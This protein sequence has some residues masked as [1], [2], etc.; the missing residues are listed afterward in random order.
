MWN[1]LDRKAK[2][3]LTHTESYSFMRGSFI[4]RLVHLGPI[5]NL[6]DQHAFSRIGSLTAVP[7]K[8]EAKPQKTYPCFNDP[9]PCIANLSYKM[10]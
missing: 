10:P 6:L 7:V 8:Y 4:R 3:D 2:A 1:I 5:A 9:I